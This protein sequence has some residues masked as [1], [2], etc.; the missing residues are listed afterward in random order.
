MCSVHQILCTTVAPRAEM[1]RAK[2]SATG[3]GLH[4]SSP[5]RP[6]DK[7]QTQRVVAVPGESAQ[8]RKLVEQLQTRT[9]HDGPSAVD[10]APPKA[11]PD[12]QVEGDS[13]AEPELDENMSF[14]LEFALPILST[15]PTSRQTMSSPT[16]SLTLKFH[17]QNVCDAATLTQPPST[18]I[19]NGSPSS[20]RWSPHIRTTMRAL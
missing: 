10:T 4:F 20:Q 11:T 12:P 19:A 6:R 14:T 15:P 8:H 9:L 2:P 5:K 17:P 3:L 13:T 7:C 1:R 16:L 18:S